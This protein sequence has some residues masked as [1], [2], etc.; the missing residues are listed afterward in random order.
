MYGV[1]TTLFSV[2]VASCLCPW[3][4]DFCCA[5]L[6]IT[7][8]KLVDDYGCLECDIAYSEVSTCALHVN[9]ALSLLATEPVC[10]ELQPSFYPFVSSFED[11]LVQ[12]GMLLRVYVTRKPWIGTIQGLRGSTLCAIVC[13]NCGS[14]L[15]TT[16]SQA[17]QTK[18]DCNRPCKAVL[19]IRI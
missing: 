10:L 3:N 12:R 11:W 7:F 15:C 2:H 17:P 1:Y 19:G 5:Y 6:L 13:A 16:Q 9:I 18:G 8:A 14:T 4:F